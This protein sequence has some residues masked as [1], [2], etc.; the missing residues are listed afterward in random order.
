MAESIAIIK[1]RLLVKNITPRYPI[2][3]HWF[4]N[5]VLHKPSI[6]HA[7]EMNINCNAVII[8]KPYYDHIHIGVN[9]N[10]PK[11]KQRFSIAHEIAHIYCEHKGNISFIDSEEDPVLRK[12]A[13][14]F[15]TEILMPK[16]HVLTLSTKSNNPLNL[17]KA[18]YSSFEVSYEAACRRIIELDIYQGA[19][20]MFSSKK[21]FCKYATPNYSVDVNILRKHFSEM[22][23]TMT[24]GEKWTRNIS[25]LGEPNILFLQRF[26]SGTYLAFLVKE[27]RD[28]V[29]FYNMLINIIAQ[30]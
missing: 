21:Y 18:I 15:A 24:C 20:F 8:D 14:G 25:M 12:E 4:A 29:Q 11:N 17:A 6:I 22:C 9:I 30:S 13:D 7:R 1:A 3:I 19:F 28:P 27:E 5:Q 10:H 26:H 23:P 16:Y 2:D